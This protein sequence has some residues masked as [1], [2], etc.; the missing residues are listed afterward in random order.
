MSKIL[1]L[2]KYNCP[3]CVKV[4]NYLNDKGVTFEAVNVEDNPEIAAQYGVM[5]VPVTIILDDDGNEIQ[6]SVGF[7]VEELEEIISKLK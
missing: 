3:T 1:K 5:G 2:E 6:R 7:K 4:S